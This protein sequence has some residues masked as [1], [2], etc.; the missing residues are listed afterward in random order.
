MIRIVANKGYALPTSIDGV[1]VQKT[2]RKSA[3]ISSI[4]EDTS[5]LTFEGVE[6][7]NNG[8]LTTDVVSLYWAEV[9]ENFKLHY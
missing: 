9:K 4:P 3:P 7:N 1:E 5:I 6:E 2:S 8:E